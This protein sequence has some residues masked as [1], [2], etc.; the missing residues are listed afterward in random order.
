MKLQCTYR[1]VGDA[2]RSW[3]QGMVMLFLIISIRQ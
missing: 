1:T 2:V 3:L